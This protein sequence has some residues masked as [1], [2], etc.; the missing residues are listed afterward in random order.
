MLTNAGQEPGRVPE[1]GFYRSRDRLASS[2]NWMVT[3]RVT[4]E[5]VPGVLGCGCSSRLADRGGSMRNWKASQESL[6]FSLLVPGKSGPVCKATKWKVTFKVVLGVFNTAAAIPSSKLISSRLPLT[7]R[8]GDLCADSCSRVF[9]QLRNMCLVVPERDPE[10]TVQAQRLALSG[11][12]Q[13]I[14]KWPV[15]MFGE[16]S[17]LL[18]GFSN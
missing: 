12:N 9:T 10:N 5:G 15:A 7:R 16:V 8:Y 11:K 2:M 6:V 18:L 1:E 4:G 17:N 14:F 3:G 13:I